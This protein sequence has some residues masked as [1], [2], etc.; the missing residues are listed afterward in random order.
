MTSVLCLYI[1]A[2]L[3]SLQVSKRDLLERANFVVLCN[4]YEEGCLYVRNKAITKV[5]VSSKWITTHQL[6]DLYIV[7]PPAYPS[8]LAL[9]LLSKLK[10]HAG[11]SYIFLG[12]FLSS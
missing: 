9:T 1:N 5:K 6:L 3:V 2:I 12:K 10:T 11:S 7:C 8:I 4:H